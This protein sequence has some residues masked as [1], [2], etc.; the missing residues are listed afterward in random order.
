MKVGYLYLNLTI[1]FNSISICNYTLLALATLLECGFSEQRPF[2][3][4]EL[5]T[6]TS[7]LIMTA[8]NVFSKW[9]VLFFLVLKGRGH[10]AQFTAYTS[11]KSQRSAFGLMDCA[12]LEEVVDLE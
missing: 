12:A 6:K 3:P 9:P 7:P 11:T 8:A 10:A 4:S 2:S 1:T 5:V